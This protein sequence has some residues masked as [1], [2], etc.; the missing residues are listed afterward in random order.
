MSRQINN[1]AG[2]Y[3][4]DGP[5]NPVVNRVLPDNW[6]PIPELG[7]RPIIGTKTT[8]VMIRMQSKNGTPYEI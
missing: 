7:T 6:G 2:A 4:H 5:L 1:G 3:F 8:W